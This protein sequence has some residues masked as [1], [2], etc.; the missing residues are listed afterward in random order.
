LS[1]AIV[2]VNLLAASIIIRN[3]QFIEYLM[4]FSQQPKRSGHRRCMISLK[5][6]GSRTR[7]VCEIVRDGEIGSC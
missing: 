2:P 3:M 6:V 5:N 7:A 4:L 1:A